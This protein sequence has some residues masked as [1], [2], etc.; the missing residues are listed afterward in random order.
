LPRIEAVRT[1]RAL[2]EAE[3]LAAA[4]KRVRNI[5]RK[6]EYEAGEP[7]AARCTEPAEKDLVVALA[8]VTV[9]VRRLAAAGDYTGSLRALARVRAQVDRFFD[10]VLVNVDD[11]VQRTN[12][13][14]LLAKLEGALNQV[15]DI[16]KLAS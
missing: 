5:L 3:S 8:D 15:A 13:L 1:F 10:D 4:N 2:P 12:R 9:D 14:R 7:D 11:P 6:A 16:S